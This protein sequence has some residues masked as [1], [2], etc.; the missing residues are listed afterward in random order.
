[1]G[2]FVTLNPFRL[3]GRCD[4]PGRSFLATSSAD[5]SVRDAGPC[6]PERL[7]LLSLP[8]PSRSMLRAVPVEEVSGLAAQAAF[9]IARRSCWPARSFWSACSRLSHLLRFAGAG[10]AGLVVSVLFVGILLI[11]SMRSNRSR[12]TRGPPADSAWPLF[13]AATVA[14]LSVA[15]LGAGPVGGGKRRD[16][17]RDRRPRRYRRRDSRRGRSAG[18]HTRRAGC[19][20]GA[21]GANPLQ[22]RVQACPVCGHW[23]LAAH[24]ARCHCP[25]RGC[26]RAGHPDGIYCCDHNTRRRGISGQA[27]NCAHAFSRPPIILPRHCNVGAEPPALLTLCSRVE[28]GDLL[29]APWYFHS[30]IQR[31]PLCFATSY[32]IAF[33]P[34]HF[35]TRSSGPCSRACRWRVP[36][37]F[38][39]FAFSNRH[40]CC[41]SGGAEPSS[42]RFSRWIGTVFTFGPVTIMG[43]RARSAKSCSCRSP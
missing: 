27:A 25:W 38:G 37:A 23:W 4:T 21:R 36:I 16:S 15:R 22:H 35:L 20:A 24:A 18:G 14:V 7:A 9:A 31:A 29:G 32:S 26:R 41:P 17:H 33:T 30:L 10:V 6:L 19:G 34:L 42:H 1:M 40:G 8:P 13:S 3:G 2:P 28:A 5:G 12:R 39:P 11:G 43:H